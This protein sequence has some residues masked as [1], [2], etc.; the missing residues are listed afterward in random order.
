MRGIAEELLSEMF[1]NESGAVRKRKVLVI[2]LFLWGVLCFSCGLLLT[3]H[4]KKQ[5]FKEVYILTFLNE[6]ML[7]T[8]KRVESY[9]SSLSKNTYF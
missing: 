6:E 9:L 1:E 3:L 2:G 4:M 7:M 8:N 5:F